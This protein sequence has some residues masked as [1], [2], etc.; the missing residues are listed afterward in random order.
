MAPQSMPLQGSSK[1]PKFEGDPTDLVQFL[2][3]V[4]F[5]CEDAQLS[6]DKDYI[7][8]VT[9]YASHDEVELWKTVAPQV[10]DDWGL[11]KKVV[12]SFYLGAEEDNDHKYLCADLDHIVAA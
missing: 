8:W 6:S 11:F 3:D 12:L 2:E 4:E 1:A 5:L 7:K 9:R 10:K